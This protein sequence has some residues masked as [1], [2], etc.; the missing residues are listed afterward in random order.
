MPFLDHLLTYKTT[1]YNTRHQRGRRL[2]V[3]GLI[4]P[5]LCA[6]G[7]NPTDRRATEPGWMDIKFCKTT[8][9][10]STRSW[11][12][13]SN[14]SSH[15]HWLALPSFSCPTQSSPQSGVRT[16][17]SDPLCS[18]DEPLCCGCPQED[19]TSPKVQQVARESHGKMQKS[20]D[21]MVSKIKKFGEEGFWFFIK[22]KKAQG[23][24]SLGVDHSSP[25]K[26]AP[27]QEPHRASSFEPR[28]GEDNTQRRRKSS[29]ARRSNSTTGL[30]RVQTEETQLDR[31]EEPP[32]SRWNPY[33]Q[34]ELA[35]L[36]Q[37]QG[38][39]THFNEEEE[40]EEPQARSSER[41]PRVE[42][43]MAVCP[44]LTTTLPPSSLGGTEAKFGGAN[45][46]SIELG[47]NQ[48]SGKN[49][50]NPKEKEFS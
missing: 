6:A 35:M 49:W 27:A 30:D 38:S 45:S 8:T 47:K 16:L 39:H 36:H 46:S 29:K 15:I 17:T 32:Q 10:L 22:K 13:G 24:L 11:M 7:V 34:Y 21:K 9:S 1:A 25:P 4:T 37:G 48:K 31:A 43:L 40:E 26:E 23:P 50:E 12:G 42:L 18:K 2:S 14:S 20:M 41:E 28:E 3:G 5:I 33:G 44:L 19:W